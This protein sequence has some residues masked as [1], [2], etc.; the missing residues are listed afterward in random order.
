[1]QM[2]KAIIASLLAMAGVVAHAALITDDFNR[3]DTGNATGDLSAIG[4]WENSGSSTWKIGGNELVPVTKSSSYYYAMNNALETTDGA[5]TL[6]GTV[7]VNTVNSAAY[8]GMTWNHTD[9][10]NNYV[11]RYYQSGATQVLRRT[12]G[13]WAVI[14]NVAGAFSPVNDRGYEVTI[15]SAA[16]ND[17]TLTITDTVTSSDVYTT[18]WTDAANTLT[19]GYGGFFANSAVATYDDFSLDAIPEPTTLGL[20]GA[21]ALGLVFIRKWRLF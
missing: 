5:F 18:S 19:G 14:K 9:E 8:V 13:T 15:S 21:T 6:K 1:M 11:M 17:F 12:G 7:I 2:K 3:P 10:N 4:S 20:L 16:I